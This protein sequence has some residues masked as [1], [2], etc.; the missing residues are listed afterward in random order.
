M[1]NY[2]ADLEKLSKIL[3]TARELKG[4]SQR[5]VARLIKTHHSTYNELEKGNIKKPDVDMLRDIAEVLDISLISLLNAAGYSGITLKF[6][7]QYH[8]NKSS[9]DIRNLLDEY[10]SSQLDLLDD[11]FKKR[12]NVRKCRLRIND[13]IKRLENYE[14]NKDTWT[15]EKI[16]Q[17]LNEISDN[18]VMSQ[19]KY[20]YSKLP[21]DNM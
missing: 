5:K 2:G 21:K 12:D 18:L 19:E 10:K 17:E 4:Y 13:L 3:S 20:D 8:S 9:K 15:I 11:A 14:I 7:E 1:E 6:R 16:T